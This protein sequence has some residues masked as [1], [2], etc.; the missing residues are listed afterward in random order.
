M[1]KTLA[2]STALIMSL[3]V[4]ACGG[5]DPEEEEYRSAVPTRTS[6]ALSVPEVEGGGATSEGIG[7]TTRKVLG[8]RA[9][10]YKVTYEVS[11]K[12]N[13]SL[14]IGL[15]TIEDIV[16]HPP[17]SIKN[18][19]A[20]W[21]PWAPALEPLS[22][23]LAVTRKGPGQ[24]A[25]ALMA[26]Q[27]AD[28]MGKFKVILAGTSTKGHSP[29]FSG[30]K[31]LY[32]ANADNLHALDPVTYPSTSKMA[33]TYDTTGLKR[34]VKL[35][36]TNYADKDSK[37]AVDAVYSYTDHANTAGEFRFALKADV[38]KN[39]SKDELY[40]V[41]S[42]WD[43]TGAGKG[44]AAVTGGDIKAGLTVKQTECWDT[45]FRRVFYKDNFNIHPAEGDPA[46]CAF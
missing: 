17:T 8:Q 3:A 25:Y 9:D 34:T 7:S 1:K 16:S 43:K 11:R 2:I 30:F 24:Y 23:M 33:A 6:L 44:V 18:G 41:V 31:G 32:T 42:A 22:W 35:V 26:R 40:A 39:G 21:G 20:T 27:K 4:L 13:R 37:Q 29:V 10:L 28:P 15:N 14:W 19:V 36:L 38:H 46:K 5:L 12:L 45:S